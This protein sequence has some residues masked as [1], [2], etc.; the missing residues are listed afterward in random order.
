MKKEKK[1]VYI[2]RN[3]LFKDLSMIMCNNI[4]DIDKSFIEDN[5]D[6]FYVECEECGGSGEKG[7]K[8]C[9]E[10]WGEGRH[11]LE[12]YQYFIIDANEYEL[13]RLKEYGVRVGYSELLNM[14][15]LPI[16]DFGTSWSAFSYSKEVD[17][18]YE[19]SY[20]ETLERKTVY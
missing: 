2:T 12:A 17:D 4:E 14:H 10:C 8:Q 5:M 19:L 3:A 15:I 1:T 6:L 18:D 9:E 16:Y 7:G 13:S 20:D 11:A